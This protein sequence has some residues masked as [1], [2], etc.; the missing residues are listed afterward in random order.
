MQLKFKSIGTTGNYVQWLKGFKDIL[1]SVIVEVDLETQEFIAKCFPLEKYIVK[2][3][4]LSFED[5]GLELSE[6]IDNNGDTIDWDNYT[7]KISNRVKVGI[8]EILGK[9]I[10]VENMFS[11]TDHEM[12]INFDICNN[13]MYIGSKAAEKEYQATNITLKSMSL[14]MVIPCSQLSEVFS[15]CDDET[16]L[17]RVCNIGSPS[18]YEV[19]IDTINNLSKISSVFIGKSRD[20]IKFYSKEE[21][22]PKFSGMHSVKIVGWGSSDENAS[23]EKNPG[24]NSGKYWIIENSWGE[25]WGEEGYFR[26]VTVN[27][28]RFQT[29][30]YICPSKMTGKK[31]SFAFAQ[32]V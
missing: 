7:E 17:N 5:A 27:S 21:D 26:I 9:V 2:Y 10:D 20:V 1:P 32:F 4:K 19:S 25:D 22:V 11:A 8:Y 16:F 13:V 24:E 18:V 12:L 15:K 14:T 28:V 30:R 3:S 6:I 23:G 29:V 31:I